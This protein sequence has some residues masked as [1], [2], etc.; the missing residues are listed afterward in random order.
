MHA[1][2]FLIVS[3]ATISLVL[4][5]CGSF[6]SEVKDGVLSGL[7]GSEE[8]AY[9]A[10]L[11]N[12]DSAVSSLNDYTDLINAVSDEMDYLESDLFY[13]TDDVLSYEAGVYEPYFSC[14]YEP[15]NYEGL[16]DATKAPSNELD[17]ADQTVIVDLAATIF[18]AADETQQLCRELDRY[19]SAQDYKDDAFARSTELVDAMYAQI[20]AYYVAHESLATKLDELYDI[21][22]NFVVD[23]SDPVSVGIGNMK[24]ALELVDQ[25]FDAVDSAY[26]TES[27]EKLAELETLYAELEV[28]SS[29]HAANPGITDT[30][31]LEYYNYFYTDLQDDFLPAAKRSIRAF[32]NQSWDELDTAYWD[33][34]DYYGFLVGD[35]N[36]YLDMAG[37]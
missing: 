9:D 2:R 26:D 20:D 24:E 15:Y 27:F 22:E 16:R 37:Y 10:S 36:T 34:S 11:E 3:L 19:V 32:Q 31:V 17:E 35:Y 13:Y 28:A 12:Y 1:S 6:V 23:P 4:T 25:F 30:S 8:S 18:E 29:Q 5:G 21:H 33:L 7:S 14:L